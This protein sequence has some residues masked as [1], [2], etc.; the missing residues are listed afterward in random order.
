MSTEILIAG[1]G[2]GGVATALACARRG[3]TVTVLERA[4]EFG[5]VGAGLQIGPNAWRVL[6][7]LGVLDGLAGR[8]VLPSRWA[9]TDIT[10]GEEIF[11]LPFG[12]AFEERYG[13]PYAVMHRG[14]LLTALITACRGTGLVTLV[15]GKEITEVG[16]DGESATAHCADG[17]SLT[18]DALVAADGL[19]SVIRAQLLDAEPPLLSSYVVYRGPGPRPEGIEDAV[20]LYVGDGIHY[21]QYPISGGTMLNRVASFKSTR[22]EPGTDEW[23]TPQELTEKFAGAMAYVRQAVAE[24]DIGKRWPLCDRKPLAGWAQGR[25]TLLGDAAH[26]MN[27]YLAQ[28]ACQALEDALALGAALA[29]TP[30]DPAAAFKSYEAARFPRSSAVQEL[31]RFVGDFCHFGGAAALLRDHFLARLSAEDR[32]AY[33]DWLYRADGTLPSRALPAHVDLYALRS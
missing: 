7:E 23:G 9:L 26:P 18:A 11:S 2:I 16:Q 19:R 25:I 17:T 28:G 15:P 24:M 8:A 6:R 20:M 27:Q 1:G 3:I 31:T 21:M 33:T 14:E 30:G 10:T 32:Y 5:E 29:E 13:A 12:E 4:A 22:G